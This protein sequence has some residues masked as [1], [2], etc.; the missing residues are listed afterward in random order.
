MKHATIGYSTA[1]YRPLLLGLIA[2]SVTAIWLPSSA[3]AANLDDVIDTG[4]LGELTGR[5]VPIG[6]GS[7]VDYGVGA[8]GGEALEFGIAGRGGEDARS[9]HFGELEGEDGDPAGT[10]NQHSL[11]RLQAAGLEKRMPGGD[12]CAG[13]GSGFFEAQVS[14]EFYETFG[15]QADLFGEHPIE[16]AAESSGGFRVVWWSGQPALHESGGDSVARCQPVDTGADGQD[17]ARTV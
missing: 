13:Q 12:S 5:F 15:I 6:S 1:I 11:A 17:F 7:V 4:A 10:L 2:L 14:G 3:G 16:G 8:H 9:G